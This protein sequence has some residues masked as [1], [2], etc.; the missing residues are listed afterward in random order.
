MQLEDDLIGHT[1]CNTDATIQMQPHMHATLLNT[2]RG[3][4]NLTAVHT[5]DDLQL[6][7]YIW[8][9]G[10]VSG[11]GSNNHTSIATAAHVNGKHC[12]AAEPNSQH[13]AACMCCNPTARTC[14]SSIGPQDGF[15]GCVGCI[16]CCCGP[17]CPS[18][19][20][21]ACRRAAGATGRVVSLVWPV[22]L[23]GWRWM[24]HVS[25]DVHMSHIQVRCV[26]W[27]SPALTNLHVLDSSIRSTV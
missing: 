20:G 13:A 12:G 27:P 23:I 21:L 2:M 9:T 18:P 17:R 19:E 6:G 25:C 10:S 1:A 15:L 7:N 3:C 8:C 26:S 16:T 11:C 22:W 4:L 14:C 24:S 5:T